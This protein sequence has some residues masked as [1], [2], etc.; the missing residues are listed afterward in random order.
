[1]QH[2]SDRPTGSGHAAILRAVCEAG[3]RVDARDVAGYTA[4]AHATAHHP[5]LKLAK[6]RGW[7]GA[8]G[9]GGGGL[10]PDPM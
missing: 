1:M 10:A 8:H 2:I 7:G 3:A 6:V 4:L 9:G 5:Q